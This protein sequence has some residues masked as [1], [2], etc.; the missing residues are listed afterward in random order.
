MIKY[1]VMGDPISHSK[2]PQ[3]HSLFA[4]QTG[5]GLHYENCRFPLMTAAEVRVFSRAVGRAEYYYTP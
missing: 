4:Q 2:S 1:A 5:E 3:I